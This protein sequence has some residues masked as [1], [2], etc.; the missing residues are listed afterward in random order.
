VVT[1]AVFSGS[2]QTGDRL[3]L[4]PAGQE[5]RVRSIH[6]QGRNADTG[7]AGERCALNISGAGVELASIHRGDWLVSPQQDLLSSRCDVRL[8][9]LASETTALKH[10][11]PIHVHAG[12]GSC[13]G[14]IALLEDRTLA[15]GHQALA[16]LVLEQPA[17][18]V[19]GDRFVIRDQSAQRT[20]G[21]GYVI[22]PCA[23]ERGRS[24]PARIELLHKLDSADTQAALAA[25]L[26]YSPG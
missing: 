9:L 18:L 21:G 20:L 16:Q 2:V 10:W 25:L 1:G 13:T 3:R 26:E 7:L 8:Q 23:P 14:R 5:V 11:T 19:Y 17:L 24:R 22:D 4:L 12:S 6:S 15:P